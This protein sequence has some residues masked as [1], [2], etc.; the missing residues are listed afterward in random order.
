MNDTPRPL[1]YPVLVAAPCRS[2]AQRVLR[3]VDPCRWRYV[4]ETRDVRD[5]SPGHPYLLIDPLGVATLRQGV[6]A[7]LRAR[8]REIEL[9]DL[10]PTRLSCP[11]PTRAAP[12][13]PAGG[14]PR[15]VSSRRRWWSPCGLARARGAVGWWWRRWASSSSSPTT[16][17]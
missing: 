12:T 8:H 10:P 13:T 4:Q 3:D 17:G 11:T 14:M 2:D 5:V 7:E 16:T 6:L 15:W 1:R 9:A